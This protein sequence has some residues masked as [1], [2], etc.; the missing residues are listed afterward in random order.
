MPAEEQKRSIALLLVGVEDRLV[1]DTAYR[2]NGYPDILT[3]YG[4]NRH[5]SSIET[6]TQPQLLPSLADCCYNEQAH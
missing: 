2:D 4:H 3:L 1:S 5:R 6:E